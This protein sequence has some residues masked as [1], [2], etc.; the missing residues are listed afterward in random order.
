MTQLIRLSE[1]DTIVN[2]IEVGGG[3]SGSPEN[4]NLGVVLAD[5]DHEVPVESDIIVV[6]TNDTI[7][8][9]KDMLILIPAKGNLVV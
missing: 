4:D 2:S 8:T 9:N 3:S 6:P 1:G 7:L 5:D